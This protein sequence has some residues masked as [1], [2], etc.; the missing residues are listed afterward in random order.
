M[1]D[2]IALNNKV[3]LITGGAR[4]IGKGISK[5]FLSCNAEVIICGRSKP[6]TLPEVNEKKARFLPCDVREV[7][8]IDVCIAEIIKEYGKLD[9]L[10][11]NAGGSP[12][13]D[14][15]TAS[16]RFSEAIIKLN[17]IAPINVS[18]AAN[19]IMQNQKNGGT[20]INIA[21]V[22]TLRPSPGTAAYGAAKAGL[23]NLTGSLAVEWAPKVRVNSI[24]AGLTETEQSHLHYGD[25]KGVNAISKTIPM[26]RLATPKDIGNACV[27]LASDLASYI[28]GASIEV[29][30]GGEKPAYLS[31]SNSLKKQPN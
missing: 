16:P 27:F 30:G 8:Q 13:A 17:L 2:Q 3:I 29:H 7:E 10:V 11:N 18:Q 14:A 25:S 20:I 24:I 4:G 5:T 1:Q 9:I 21:S 28:N 15:A 31:A 26:L 12:I 19:R 23:V 6:E 22:S